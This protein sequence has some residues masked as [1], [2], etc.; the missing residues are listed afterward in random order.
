MAEVDRRIISR[1]CCTL[2]HN[3]P[4]KAPFTLACSAGLG[5]HAPAGDPPRAH[6]HAEA[7]AVAATLFESP[8]TETASATRAAGAATTTSATPAATQTPFGDE[9]AAAQ[10]GTEA[11]EELLIA[12]SAAVCLLSRSTS[13]RR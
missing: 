10:L 8:A 12:S 6:R 4:I 2:W 11:A 7:V 13:I 3:N 9:A 5:A 1:V